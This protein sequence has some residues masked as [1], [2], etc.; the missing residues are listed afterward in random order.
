LSGSTRI[1]Q[2][3]SAQSA[4]SAFYSDLHHKDNHHA[5]TGIV[6]NT[7]HPPARCARAD[8]ADAGGKGANL[9]VMVRAGL[10]VPPASSCST[11]GYRAFVAAN[12][13]APH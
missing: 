13:L 3:K 12:A 6:A 11:D 7:F 2:R 4:S 1:Y 10:P 5:D 8:A 9:G